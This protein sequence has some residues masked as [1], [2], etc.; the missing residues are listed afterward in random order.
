MRNY[1]TLVDVIQGNAIDDIGITFISNGSDDQ[2]LS[3][4]ELYQKSLRLLRSLQEC[5]VKPGNEVVFQL[6]DNESF[7]IAFWGCVLGGMIP[8]PITVGLNDEHRRKLFKIW[9]VLNS[10]YLLTKQ[11]IVDKLTEKLSPDM[12]E[13]L[14]DNV[15]HR[16][17]LFEALVNNSEEGAI[18]RLSSDSPAF[19]QF[20]SGSTGNPKGVVLTHENLISNIN[21][22]AVCS[23]TTP[24][25]SSL[26]WMPLT[27][28]MGLIGFHISPMGAGINQYM[29]STASFIRNPVL[30]FDK[31]HEY[32]ATLLASPNFGYKH[33]LTFFKEDKEKSWDLSNVRLIFNGAEPI[34]AELSNH[35]YNIMS[36]WGLK[37]TAAFPVYGLAE[38]SLAV[39]FPPVYEGLRRIE[40]KR[41]SISLGQAIVEADAASADAV[42]FVDLGYPVLDCKVRIRDFDNNMLPDSTIGQIQITGK[43]VTKGYYNNQSET[44]RITTSDGWLCTGDLG[45]MKDGRLFVT[46]R[47]KDI[48]F[49]NGQNYYPHDLERIAGEV[50]GAELGK[51]AICGIYNDK[52]EKEEIVVFVLYKGKLEGFVE[53]V[54]NVKRCINL[55]T[56][57]EVSYVVPILKMP[58]TTSGKLQ[59]FALKEEFEKG[60]YISVLSEIDVLLKAAMDQRVVDAP[61]NEFEEKLAAIWSEVLEISS[62]GINDNFFELGGDSIKAA[63]IAFKAYKEMGIELPLSEFFNVPTIKAISEYA[64]SADR[65]DYLEIPEAEEREYYP[66]SSAQKRMFILNQL[67]GSGITYNISH[68]MKINGSIDIARLNKALKD[69]VER[70]ESLRTSFRV[71][72]GEPVQVIHKDLQVNVDYV[73][74]SD[75]EEHDAIARYIA[76]FDLEKAPLF[77]LCIFEN[78]SKEQLLVFDAHHIAFDGTSVSLFMD[79][80]LRAYDGISRGTQGL[81]YKDYAVWQQKQ[82][83]SEDLLKQESFWLNAFQEGIPVLDM[84]IDYQRPSVQSFDGDRLC[85]TLPEELTD[86]LR[87]LAN[88]CGTSVYMLLLSAYYILLNKYTGQEDI[89]IGTPTIGRNHPELQDVLGMF[90]NTVAL[91]NKLSVDMG[92]KYFLKAITKNTLAAFENQDY[93]LEQLVSKLGI[94]RDMRR[95]PLFDTMF[96]FQNIKMSDAESREL[97]LNKHDY[98]NKIS[99]FDVTLFAEWQDKE[100]SCEIEYCTALYK[101]ESMASFSTHYLNI[102]HSIVSNPD[103]RLSE[104]KVLSDNEEKYLLYDFN[105]TDADFPVNMTMHQIF[106]NQVILN[107]SAPAI[108]YEGSKITYEELNAR[109]N[110]LARILVKNGMNKG[111]IGAIVAERSPEVVVGILAILKAGGAFLPVDPDYPAERISFMLKDSGAKLVLTQSGLMDKLVVSTKL[112]ILDKPELYQGECTDLAL[113]I[114]PEDMIYVIYTSGSTGKPKGA[115]LKHRGA[116][117]Y[118]H[119]AA[120]SYLKG[121]A[122]NMPLY[123]SISFDLTITSIFTPLIT[124]NTVV[125]YKDD[126]R[127]LLIEKVMEEN[128]VHVVKL[129]PAHLRII[130]DKEL[131]GCSVKRL[132][133]GGEQLDAS[134][135]ASVHKCFGGEVEIYNEYGPTE[136]TV[137]CMIYKY[138]NEVDCRAAV[139]IGKPADNMQIYLLDKGLRAVPI[140]AV[141]EIYIGGIGLA[142][143][144]LNRE[145]LT[146][147]RFISNPFIE[148]GKLYKTGDLG[149]MLINGNIEFIGR[150][151]HQVKIRG[152]RIELGEIESKLLMHPKIKE[153]VVAAKVDKYNNSFLCAYVVE[154]EEMSKEELRAHLQKQLPDYMIPAYFVR[155]DYLPMTINGKLD[156]KALPEPQPEVNKNAD[157]K[158]PATDLEVKM[159]KIWE[160][161][162]GVQAIGVN[163]NYFALGGD[164]IKAIQ[165]VS[166]LGKD[167]LTLGIKDILTYQTI[168]SV[169]MNVD[170]QAA[171]KEYSQDSLVGSIELFPIHRWFVE[172]KLN[173]SNHYNQSICL[174]L[175]KEI[176]RKVLKRAFE[177]LINHHDGL[178]LNYSTQ[179]E[180]LFYNEEHLNK[181]FVVEEFDLSALPEAE[182]EC[183]LQ[184][185]GNCLK[186]GFDIQKDLLVKAAL[187][188]LSDDTVCLLITAHHFVVDGVS[189]MVLLQ[190][191]FEAIEKLEYENE[192]IMPKKTASLIDWTNS[193]KEYAASRE[194]L[195]E[196]EYWKEQVYRAEGSITV[197]RNNSSKKLEVDFTLDK[198]ETDKLVSKCNTPY[199]TDVNELLIAALARSIGEFCKKDS[200]TL[201]LEGHGRGLDSADAS[202]TI[203]WFTALYPI[204]LRIEAEAI[205]E[206]IKST[207]EQLRRIPNGG[208]GFGI[209]KYL[210]KEKS[211]ANNEKPELRFNYLGKFDNVFDSKYGELLSI[212]TGD[213]ICRTNS[214][215]ADLEINCMIIN[216]VL[217]TQLVFDLDSYTESEANI[218]AS[219]YRDQLRE[220]IE[221][222]YSQSEVFYTPSDFETIDIKQE[223]LDS[224]F[225]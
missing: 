184:Q 66:F 154:S 63:Y 169:C 195:L 193:L 67:E 116:V 102:L 41:N 206:S 78:Q 112:I 73:K 224:L 79:E 132:I 174:K 87:L 191:L 139:P 123:T 48:I 90:V 28:D 138:D 147:E 31:V 27:H 151:D 40:I 203:G 149:K 57:L 145:D 202:R 196:S 114:D 44:S 14:T 32:K 105:N 156:L 225:M 126:S 2:Y 42:S 220:I 16:T 187:V 160:D 43:N 182:A 19:I 137:G 150:I 88:R 180:L 199:N 4:K 218:F 173:N 101:K 205:G 84:H 17:I 125:I 216:D 128:K 86:K 144:Y 95:N 201:E 76:P 113:N 185:I 99:K 111:D 152:Y 51:T 141:G 176:D 98:F 49:I 168:S 89:V 104:I 219:I 34:S 12:L 210:L 22:I 143:G 83:E 213:D 82:L 92:F 109:A 177:I 1:I 5:G 146:K 62:V 122:L 197:A 46:G 18:F 6:D 25:D 215:T 183:R 108:E 47:A 71:V 171:S 100:I 194:L 54:T 21:A 94:K 161:V 198:T 97:K 222:T 106:E 164:S 120:K 10:P 24:D 179:K 56:G 121:E 172:Q 50:P 190:D 136:T 214:P 81:Q 167:G 135:A 30:W 36:N 37:K 8:V 96:V 207:K 118:I 166:R 68:T 7:I 133:V 64:A 45:F 60:L 221:H 155:L 142:S 11:G 91:R 186:S 58:K 157:F 74:I 55:K 38:A 77:R 192:P 13:D 29:M 124:G 59:R 75:E 175:K 159:A 211:L 3:Y 52:T 188:N 204:K 61:T 181:G 115:M 162:L 23:E 189:W 129:T 223:D 117:N 9:R 39:S 20:S 80:L 131:T 107:P 70:H 119:W 53:I 200:L 15:L 163:D 85:F 217:R 127:K 209:M 158:A 178:R 26:G 72:E 170:L 208:I 140:N 165:I 110:Q 93:Q 103:S 153:A 35:F 212:N 134:L 148:G 33:F 130:K 65:A 69:I